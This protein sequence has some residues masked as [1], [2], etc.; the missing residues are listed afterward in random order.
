MQGHSGLELF[1]ETTDARQE[2]NQ[3]EAPT[4]HRALILTQDDLATLMYF[5]TIEGNLKMS[6]QENMQT[7]HV[8]G[9]HAS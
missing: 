3:D 7:P 4:Y 1:L 6:P 2:I 5:W 8:M 9:D